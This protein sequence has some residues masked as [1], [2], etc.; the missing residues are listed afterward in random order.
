MKHRSVL[1]S[2]GTTCRAVAGSSVRFPMPVSVALA[3]LLILALADGG[4][5]FAAEFI[6]TPQTDVK[7]LLKKIA[8][9][10]SLILENG[11]WVDADL[12]FELLPGTVQQPVTIRAETA[13]QVIFTGQT[14][15]RVSGQYV[16][17]SGLVF[18]NSSGRSDVVELR[19]HSE[20]HAHHCR[21]TDCVFEESPEADAMIESRWLSIYGTE[22]RIDHCYFSGKKNRGPT[23][24]VW[25]NGEPQHH[26]IDHNHFGARPVLGRN[27]GETLRLGTSD[28]SEHDS[29]SIV[30]HN[31]FH[32][33]D[34]EAEIISNKSCGNVYRYNVFD[35]C[36]GALTLRHGHRCL[37]E[38]NIFLG[39]R[40]RGTGGVR[41]IGQS[42]VVI[43][44]Y[45]EGLRGDAERA[46]VSMMNG[47]LNSP[48]N[49]YSPVRSATVSHNTF[50]D[51][52]VSLEFG[53]GAG[54]KQSVAPAECRITYNLFRPDKW[55]I[56]RQHAAI[57]SFEWA[58]NKHQV[59]RVIE[60]QPVTFER[61]DLKLQPASDGLFR[62]MDSKAIRADS[63]SNVKRDIDGFARSEAGLSGCDD[64]AT[65]FR[66]L[67][68]PLNTGP[69]WRRNNYSK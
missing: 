6:L 19:T 13:G 5:T 17:V 11:T 67:A 24:V 25:V 55:S 27:G 30:E 68:S 32:Q 57:D 14:E 56:I 37:V 33:C 8:A 50:V 58:G 41:I 20:R 35:E 54:R 15:F 51:C 49:G 2:T 9:G 69:V 38:G 46:A 44:N 62:P 60:D 21:L 43:N 18:R 12:K 63:V 47:I 52:K 22:N 3:V 34:G 61:A 1:P 36:S 26:R 45:F 4:G 10:D 23:V 59:G 40:K 53:V 29:K 28:V 42:H 64:P 66:M 31:Y 48:L 39:R 7:V 16:I 65:S